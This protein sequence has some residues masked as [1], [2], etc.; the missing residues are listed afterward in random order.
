MAGGLE[1]TTISASTLA[2]LRHTK[3]VRSKRQGKEGSEGR[4]QEDKETDPRRKEEE[5]KQ[6]AKQ[7]AKARREQALRTLDTLMRRPEWKKRAMLSRS[8]SSSRLMVASASF[9]R[10]WQWGA[11]EVEEYPSDEDEDA[12]EVPKSRMGNAESDRHMRFDDCR[13]CTFQPKVGRGW[14]GESKAADDEDEDADAK[15]DGGAPP[16]V[17]AFIRRQD[18]WV[19]K[20]RAEKEH[21]RGKME[22]EALL[23]RKIC[24][25]CCLAN[26]T[27]VFQSYDEF[28]EKRDV[29]TACG[30]KY[31]RQTNW[32]AVRDDFFRN[33]ENFQARKEKNLTELRK[34]HFEEPCDS[35]LVTKRTYDVTT[36][37]SKIEPVFLTYSNDKERELLWKRFLIRTADDNRRR[38]KEQKRWARET[39]DAPLD[40]E[41][42]FRPAVTQLDGNPML[43]E[44]QERLDSTTFEERNEEDVNRRH[45]RQ[46]DLKLEK[47]S[48]ENLPGYLSDRRGWLYEERAAQKHGAGYWEAKGSPLMG[49]MVAP[50][51][52]PKT[53][54][55]AAAE[56]KL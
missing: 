25:E 20:T 26:G 6:K 29:C 55:R 41:C 38:Q 39:E 18:G 2:M 34:T 11:D 7:K 49:D 50:R 8:W 9:D 13:H 56:P 22:Y 46:E 44:L 27:P 47:P 16:F 30:N 5:R 23:T 12:K 21:T 43:R 53:L 17:K 3:R 28:L 1:G 19:K 35:R 52:E 15:D 31:V 14:K 37:K 40:P 33:A 42:T 45:Q 4:H 48:E 10:D 54:N 32:A 36:D 24:P 51:W